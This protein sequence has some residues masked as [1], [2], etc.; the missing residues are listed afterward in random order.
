MGALGMI[1]LVVGG[2]IS[3]IG[4]IWFIIV[5]FQESVLWGLGCLL[6]PFVSLIFLITHWRDASR[7]FWVSLLGSIITLVATLMMPDAIQ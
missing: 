1:L 5:A 7:P 6:I 3:A 2:I 4:G